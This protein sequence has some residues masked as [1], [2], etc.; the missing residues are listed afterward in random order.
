MCVCIQGLSCF[1]NILLFCRQHFLQCP[2]GLL[3]KHFEKLIQCDAR[4][5]F[6]SQ[7]PAIVLGSLYFD[8][9]PSALVEPD[10]SKD[11]CLDQGDDK[12]SVSSRVQ[13]IGSPHAS[14]SQSSSFNIETSDPS[15]VTL[16]SRSRE[17][18]SPSS[19][20]LGR[21]LSLIS[22]PYVPIHFF[23]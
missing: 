22:M 16:D 21:G 3:N 14:Q 7:Q 11:H 1:G 23:V 4:L 9:R 6:L 13:G 20:K 12:G 5:N 17:A 8:T 15:C 10:E 19:G 18:P 2:Q